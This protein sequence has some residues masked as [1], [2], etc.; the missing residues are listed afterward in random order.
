MARTAATASSPPLLLVGNPN[1]GKSVIF[2]ALAKTYVTVANYPGTT[3][4]LARARAHALQGFPE[5]V[6]TP[7]TNSLLPQSEDER[8][9][10]DLLLQEPRATVIQVADMKNL[11]RAL[12]LTLQLA[13]LGRRQILLLNLQ[14]EARDL[15]VRVDRAR[16]EERLGIPVIAT[17]AI[18]RRGLEMIPKR[19]PQAAVAQLTASY[20]L[21]VEEAVVRVEGLLPARWA[22]ARRGLALMLLAGDETLLPWLQREVEARVLGEIGAV[23]A[24]LERQLG[25]R[26]AGVLARAR[27]RAVEMLL[28]ETYSA[29]RAPYGS[30]RERLGSLT[31][32]PVWGL[33]FLVLV[34]VS[35]YFFVGVFG[36]G[37]L[38][39]LIEDGLFGQWINPAAR[40]LA[41]QIL[42]P[43]LFYDF[44]VGPYGLITMALTYSLAIVLPVV[45]TFFV[46]FG[47][48]ED[49]GY[50]PRLAVMLHRLF[51]A[52][53]LNGKA[54]LPMVLGLGCDTMATLT[55]RI[56]PTRK[57]RV[58]V[59][60][61]LAL[62]VPCSAQ[63][64]VILA[65]LASVSP[66]GTLLWAGVV[67]GVL[68][69]VGWAAARLLPGSNS[70]F[71]LEVPP[72][73][74]PSLANI[75]IKTAARTEWYLKEAVPLFVLGTLVLF[76]L[77]ATGALPVVERAA[78][79]LVVGLLDLPEKASEAFLI[80]FLRR[81]YGAAGLFDM[82]QDGLLDG[83]QVVV[84]LVVITLFVP[85]IANFFVMVKE[86]GV[87]AAAAMVAFIVPFAFLV[88][89]ALNHV[90]RLV[91]A[92]L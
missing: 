50:L 54:V 2:G 62:G 8:V 37:T 3:V 71:L 86:R 81:D 16:L 18:R 12:Y 32:H 26:V 60:L 64:G 17:T 30:F 47:L 57:E 66:L 48:L 91:G 84:S 74:L 31:M 55:T 34:L 92:K 56:L 11:R 39:D 36:A 6:D 69:G 27:F 89:A 41:S 5:V 68:F 19:L 28:Q 42:G 53:G 79:P 9:T 21:A 43:G 52:M 49:S 45:G 67:M 33:F 14:D 44:L 63:L 4:E 46:F 82:R 83:V 38:V 7:G 80:G 76:L 20:P 70:D 75:A 77:D 51:R 58:V 35:A 59:T 13:E 1:V 24:Q 15:G 73:R 72:I 10:R 29:D 40:R 25:R 87:K 61:L 90:L 22:E 88:G 23:R 65:M 78:R 85:C